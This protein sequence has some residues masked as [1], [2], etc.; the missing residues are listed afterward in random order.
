MRQF[1]A[2][3][4]VAFVMCAGLS[5]LEIGVSYGRQNDEFFVLT[6][7]N[8]HDFYCEKLRRTLDD[9]AI[10]CEFSE[11]PR[12]GFLPFDAGAFRISH[13]ILDKKFILTIQKAAENM[14]LK[15]FAA[16]EN[17]KNSL[18]LDYFPAQ[19][20]QQNP[21][22][23]DPKPAA[24][25]PQKG[26]NFQI[27]AY[28][29]SLPFLRQNEKKYKILPINF[30]IKL[31]ENDFFPSLNIAKEPLKYA[32]G[33]DYDAY[34]KAKNEFVKKNYAL[35]LGL[36][37]DALKID[38]KSLFKSDLMYFQAVALFSLKYFEEAQN[39]SKKFPKKLRKQSAH[40]RD[41]VHFSAEF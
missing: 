17:V 33:S 23:L 37:T 34:K 6:L 9:D 24:K 27:V 41:P 15:L 21:G 18:F 29:K 36:A 40:T 25:I 1:F 12:E 8:D 14:H 39:I 38:E 19:K 3:K 32:L 16:Q 30:P 11:V 2:L 7:Q 20:T 22:N 35:A 5:A 13:E 31:D 4:I 28:K 10:R 26:K